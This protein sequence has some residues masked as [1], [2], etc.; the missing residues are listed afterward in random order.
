MASIRFGAGIVDAR[1]SISGQVF[2]RNANGGYIRARTTPT[3]PGTTPQAIVRDGLAENAQAW[4]E[5]S[6]VERQA[7]VDAAATQQGQYTNRLGETAQYTG[8]QLFMLVNQLRTSWVGGGGSGS[9]SDTTTNPP[10]LTPAPGAVTFGGLVAT[11][12][13]GALDDLT[14]AV[15]SAAASNNVLVYAS[16][17]VSAGVTRPRSVQ[18]RRI[19]ALTDLTTVG[20]LD[21]LTAYVAVYGDAAPIGSAI[22]FKLVRLSIV[23]WRRAA[24]VYVRGVV[25][26]GA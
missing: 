1:G 17:P 4:R 8:Q 16:P 2:S 26:A 23:S 24:P 19:A 21:A 14:I 9:T 15:D 3:N 12:T 10:P 18:F 11:S 22:W 5:L 20:D 13:A 7:W 6:D 25:E